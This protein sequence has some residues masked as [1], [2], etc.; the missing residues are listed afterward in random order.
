MGDCCAGYFHICQ[1]KLNWIQLTNIF[2]GHKDNAI[3]WFV[4][5]L[6]PFISC[7]PCLLSLHRAFTNSIWAIRNIL[8]LK[9]RIHESRHW[10]FRFTRDYLPTMDGELRDG[11]GWEGNG[12]NG[13][14]EYIAYAS[15]TQD[16]GCYWR[17]RNATTCCLAFCFLIS[18]PCNW[19][20]WNSLL[21]K[22]IGFCDFIIFVWPLI[23][24]Q[25]IGK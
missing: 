15:L 6:T 5:I 19:K 4:F 17:L 20:S 1:S 14:W 24:W 3:N 9:I 13:K 23:I 18:F 2:P 21:I 10:H 16:L 8:H 25:A 22:I 7:W 12:R 11:V